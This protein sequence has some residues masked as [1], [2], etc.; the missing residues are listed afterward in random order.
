MHSV[1]K[2]KAR[3]VSTTSL[4]IAW[5]H[6][7]LTTPYDAIDVP[8]SGADQRTDGGQED[9]THA[10]DFAQFLRNASIMSAYGM[11]GISVVAQMCEMDCQVL[12]SRRHAWTSRPRSVC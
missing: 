1:K 11:K 10:I 7:L 12:T 9:H 6:G 8:E 4:E 2:S 5:V 3:L